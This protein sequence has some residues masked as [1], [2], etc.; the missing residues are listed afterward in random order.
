MNSWDYQTFVRRRPE[1]AREEIA[2]CPACEPRPASNPPTMKSIHTG[3]QIYVVRTAAARKP[4][5]ARQRQ[6]RVVHVGGL[7]PVKKPRLSVMLE[8][9]ARLGAKDPLRRGH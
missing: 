7:E 3:T 2:F 4:S 5:R 6:K 8:W 9:Q 1:S